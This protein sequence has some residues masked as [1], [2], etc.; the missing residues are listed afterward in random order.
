MGQRNFKK[1]FELPNFSKTFYCGNDQTQEH[2]FECVYTMLIH[3]SHFKKQ[4]YGPESV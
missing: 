3:K 1:P 2:K 4:K